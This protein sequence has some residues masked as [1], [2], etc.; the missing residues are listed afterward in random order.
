MLYCGA[1]CFEGGAN[2]IETCMIVMCNEKSE[3]RA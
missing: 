3:L 2:F 1:V